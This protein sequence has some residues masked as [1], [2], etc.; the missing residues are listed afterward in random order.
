MAK[1]YDL[2]TCT[3]CGKDGL[4]AGC[5]HAACGGFIVAG[6]VPVTKIYCGGQTPGF[7]KNNWHLSKTVKFF[8]ADGG[9]S[10]RVKVGY[11]LSGHHR[12]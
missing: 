9:P 6:I 10:Y 2:G 8:P 3:I 5:T 12:G 4:I 1:K 7:T 11:L